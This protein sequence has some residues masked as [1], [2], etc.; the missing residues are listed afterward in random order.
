MAF[1]IN[2]PASIL[3]IF[4]GY[5]IGSILPAYIF[6]KIKHIDIRCHGTGNPGTSNAYFVLG[7]P[8]AM[9]TGIYDVV[10]GLLAML[11]ASLFGAN[12]LV[13]QLSGLATIIGH[14][15]PFYLKFKGGQGVATATG[16][17]LCCLINYFLE[18]LVILLIICY[19]IIILMI[20]Y[21]IA[22]IGT[23]LPIVLFPVLDFSIF[24]YYAN[25][26]YNII[27]LLITIHIGIVGLYKIIKERKI[28]IL[29]ENFKTYWWRVA[30][31][32]FAIVFVVF[33]VFNSLINTLILIGIIT[34][35]FTVID[36]IRFV[37]KQANEFLT[38]KIKSIFRKTEQKCFSSMTI[39]LLASFFSIL[40]FQKNIAMISIIFL[41][42]GDIFSKIFGLAFGK[43]KIF[44][45]KT[46]EGT[47]AY[48]GS[49]LITGFILYHLLDISPVI[50]ICGG[51][52]APIAEVLP[53]DMNDNFTVPI[54]SGAIMTVVMV[55]GY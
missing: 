26:Q 51:L 48:F 19:I 35:I 41:I 27:F 39:F 29:D 46:V 16:I 24:Y 25:S 1:D 14:V 6:G 40:V 21:Y 10:K 53:L 42:F 47:L 55:F 20:F 15:F 36:I 7:F 52:V 49:V 32:P 30:A 18:S 13:I 44:N 2:V 38:E 31:R 11:I 8:Y 12:F 45:T 3:S 4:L 34:A 33:Y 28:V 37:L 50:L 54:I 5:L 17:L 43:Y 23:L 9:L 22:R